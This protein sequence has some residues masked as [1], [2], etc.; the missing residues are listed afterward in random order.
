MVNVVVDLDS[1][2]YTVSDTREP[3]YVSSITDRDCNKFYVYLKF[4][5]KQKAASS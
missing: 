1:N 5:L 3:D 4:T 2:D